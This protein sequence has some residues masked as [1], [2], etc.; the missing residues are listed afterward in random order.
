M[1]TIVALVKTVPDTW[2]TKSLR[3][4]ARLDRDSVDVIID[5]INEFSLELALRV[6]EEAAKAGTD[7]QVIALS[8]GPAHHE[9]ALRKAIAMG[10]DDAVHITDEALGGSD[11]L[12]TAFALHSAV[13]TIDDVQLIVG[14]N[15]SS[16]G[17]TGT[18]PGLLAEFQEIPALTAVHEL[19]V[20]A[21]MV[22]AAREDNRGSWQL[23]ADLPALVT[24]TDKAASPRFP[25]FKGLRQAKKHEIKTVDI[26]GIEL[27]ADMVG[28]DNATTRVLSHNQRP[29]RT[30]G[31]VIDSGSP[32]EQARKIADY[33]AK[34][35][36]I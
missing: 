21:G 16:D 32:E 14:G 30:A 27:D 29:P 31:E 2:S 35:N 36:L 18:V 23:E 15:Y 13:E 22:T 24:V 26:S 5:E 4:D 20:E 12:G 33:L 34:N 1:P 7:Y 8:M 28:A 17:S 11:A 25:K 9:E 19:K 10:A 6:R 3:D